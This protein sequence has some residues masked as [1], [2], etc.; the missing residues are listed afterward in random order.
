MDKWREVIWPSHALSPF[1]HLEWGREGWWKPFLAS[2][3]KMNI[4]E[5]TDSHHYTNSLN[6]SRQSSR[7]VESNLTHRKAHI[8]FHFL[9]RS[10]LSHFLFIV[11]WK[12]LLKAK[13]HLALYLCWT[14]YTQNHKHGCPRYCLHREEQQPWFFTRA[15]PSALSPEA[16]PR[17]F[18]TPGREQ[19]IQ[20]STLCGWV[21]RGFVSKVRM[22]MVPT[23]SSSPDEVE[24]A[25]GTQAQPRSGSRSDR[26]GRRGNDSEFSQTLRLAVFDRGSAP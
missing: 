12:Y 10:S 17:C 9:R 4:S 13:L 3:G 6:E 7:K 19:H 26:K 16:S 22:V 25:W 11:I 1:A 15:P 24:V 21:L 23:P 18:L 2:G 14:P 8:C 20:S 5:V